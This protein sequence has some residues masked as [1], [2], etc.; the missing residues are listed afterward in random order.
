MK[1]LLLV[2][3]LLSGC[4]AAEN[5]MKHMKSDWV[6]LNRKIVL[7][8]SDGSILREWE[9]TAKVEDKGGTCYFINAEGKAVTISGTFV[10]EEK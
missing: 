7:Y 9:T 10:I 5:E 4:A 2:A 6:G 1:R 8:A 3:V